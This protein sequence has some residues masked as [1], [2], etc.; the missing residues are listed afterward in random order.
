MKKFAPFLFLIVFVFASAKIAP[1]ASVPYPLI[2]HS[3]ATFLIDGKPAYDNAYFRQIEFWF[4]DNRPQTDQDLTTIGSLMIQNASYHYF[5]ENGNRINVNNE[6]RS[7]NL[8]FVGGDSSYV[9]FAPKTTN[10]KFI[11]FRGAAESGLINKTFLWKLTTDEAVP[12]VQEIVPNFR[13]TAEQLTS[14]VPYIEIGSN[15]ISWRM[16]NASDPSKAVSVPFKNSYRIFLYDANNNLLARSDHDFS[17]NQAPSGILPL[18]ATPVY[19]A[20]MLAFINENPAYPDFQHRYV[21][22]FWGSRISNDGVAN[23]A[24]LKPLTLKVGEQ[25]TLK[26]ALSTGYYGHTQ[27][28]LV[29]NPVFI[30]DRSILQA[31]NVFD[32]A[33][34]SYTLTLKGLQKGTTTLSVLYWKSGDS[35]DWRTLPLNITVTDSGSSDND[36]S[37]GGGCDSG[38]AGFA[39]LTLV[40]LAFRKQ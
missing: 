10:N 33:T 26:I 2:N 23:V 6:D 19:Y 15:G 22:N 20:R 39:L 14:F 11:Y 34:N 29:Q 32:S 1:A 9:E 37:S 3:N 12:Y 35:N 13:S 38:L 8:C 4:E 36:S 30:G 31:G 21:W 7:F 40:G 25:T 27:N 28:A 17:A 18:S 24:D 5:D 16:I